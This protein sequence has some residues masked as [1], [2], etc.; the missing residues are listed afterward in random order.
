MSHPE[1]IR[2]DL[3]YVT[4]A[5]RRNQ[6]GRG[7][8]AVYFI[9]AAIVL[10]GFALPDFAP[11]LAGPFWLV[12]G[13]GGGLASWWVGRRE[14]RRSGLNDQALARRYTLHWLTSAVAYFL[15]ALPAFAG[16][17]PIQSIVSN[18]MLIGAVVYT[19]AGVHLERA[20]IW[21]GLLMFVAYIT[22]VLANPPYA[23]TASGV[24]IALSLLWSGVNIRKQ[25][26]ARVA[27]LPQ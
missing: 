1:Q 14:A 7:V 9:W 25:R 12:A 3:D 27:D 5:L 8:P 19:L 17:A 11:R 13:P 16:T 15:C 4:G 21:C 2:Q 23:W 20:L 24:V 18:F 6:P 26:N 10:V 22:L